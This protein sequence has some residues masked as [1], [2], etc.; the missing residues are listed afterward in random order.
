M[1]NSHQYLRQENFKKGFRDIPGGPM[2][3]N[4]PCSAVDKGSIPQSR[5]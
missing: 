2:V 1:L 5:T 3:R 4:P